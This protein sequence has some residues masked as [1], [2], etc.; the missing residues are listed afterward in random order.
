VEGLMA[1][2]LE[3]IVLGEGISRGGITMFPLHHP[4]KGGP[5][6]LTL[7][8]ALRRGL[9]EVQEKDAGGSV[10][11][12]KVVNRADVA[13][14]ILDG[15]ELVGAKQNR[16][17]NASVLL[18]AGAEKIIAVSCTEAGRWSYQSERF[19]ASPYVMPRSARRYKNASVHLHL[20]TFRDFR[21][22]QGQVWDSV[23]RLSLQLK[24]ESP[25]QA[26]REVLD[27]RGRELEDLVGSLRPLSDQK[28]LLMFIGEEV[29]GLDIVSRAEAYAVLHPKLMRSYA[30][31]VLASCKANPTG[32]TPGREMARAFLE[33]LKSCK[34]E[35]FSSAGLGCD[36]RFRSP[37]A[38]GSA[39]VYRKRVIHAA[40][41]RIEDEAGEGGGNGGRMAESM[42]DFRLRRSSRYY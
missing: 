34:E 20:Q 23:D 9:L 21:A 30:A 1:D 15:E 2:F 14:L 32:R 12:I 5:R 6:Y 33:E 27:S 41:F 7:D 13:V 38:L 26:M 29:A 31:D 25:T 39:L 4:Q 16:V 36:H 17:L 35:V 18:A 8:E 10:P 42:R 40:F 22:D 24:A 3:G 28:G 19:S 37:R 11:E